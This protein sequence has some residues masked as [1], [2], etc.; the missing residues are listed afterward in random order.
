M[1]G[2]KVLGGRAAGDLPR[3][4]AV[5]SR[6]LWSQGPLGAHEACG[7]QPPPPRP[8]IWNSLGQ[9]RRGGALSPPP[10]AGK[11]R[12]AVGEEVWARSWAGPRR[13]PDRGS[14]NRVDRMAE[15]GQVLSG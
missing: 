11:P 7:T 12:E 2:D 5:F 8:I 9:G 4:A 3:S 15:K 10:C 13:T 6:G 14:A 1:K